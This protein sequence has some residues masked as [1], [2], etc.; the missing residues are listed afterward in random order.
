MTNNQEHIKRL[1]TKLDRL[2]ATQNAFL[3]EISDLRKDIRLLE[4]MDNQVVEET[5][6][7]ATP[8]VEE[9]QTVDTVFEEAPIAE[10]AQPVNIPLFEE[11]EVVEEPQA[12]TTPI[13]ETPK[14]DTPTIEQAQA[15]ASKPRPSPTLFN[16]ESNLEK[17]I[18][19]NLTNK[20]GIIITILGVAIG[21]KYTID[22]DLISPLT[23]IILGYLVGLGLLGFGLKLK[24]KYT[25]YSSVLVSGAM[26]IMY[27]ITFAAFSFFGLIPQWL[28]FAL[29]VIL[30]VFTVVA[31]VSY[32]RQIIALI[33]LVGAYAVPFLLSTEPGSMTTLFAYMA[34]INA[35]ILAV[36]VFRYWKPVYYAAF[37]LTWLMY[38][39]WY[40]MSYQKATDLG[41]ALTFLTVFFAIFYATFLAYK[42][43]KNEKFRIDDIML[44]LGNSFIFFGLG[45]TMLNGH[46]TGQK[47]LGLF[48]LFNAIIHFGVSVMIYRKQLADKNLFYIVSGLVLIFITITIPIQLDGNWVTLLWAGEAALLFWIGRTKNE[49]VYEILSYPL[50]VLALLSL[51]QDWEM[52]Y[53]RYYYHDSL[54]FIPIFNIRFLSSALFIAAFSFIVYIN[55]DK[56]YSPTFN[57]EID[58]KKVIQY[59]LGAILVSV[60]YLA[61]RLEISD[62]FNQLL[63]VTHKDASGQYPIPNR[64][65]LSLKNIW[66]AIY[67][68]VFLTILS[69][70]NIKFWKNKA[71]GQFN[72]GLNAIIGVLLLAI[73]LFALSQLRNGYLNPS[74]HYQAGISAILVRYIFLAVFA[75]FMYAFHQLV[76]QGWIEDLYPKFEILLHVCIIWIL[77]S[78]LIHW[79][80]MAHSTQPYKLGLSILWGVYSLLAIALGIWK[81][82]KYLRV[83]AIV[84]FGLTLLKLFVYDIAHLNTI[85]KT[86]V[87]V[88]LGVLLLIISFLYNKYSGELASGELDSRE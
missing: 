40:T 49:S 71:F 82:K 31:A 8:I 50:M 41:T 58:F 45:Y 30:T 78:E 51:V 88:S 25:N 21:A 57:T 32:D 55:S 65:I 48:T 35:G 3:R 62:Y 73:G 29:M 69:F 77:S 44:L 14:V 18:G 1:E 60:I 61:F 10:D 79:M 22:H 11:V 54:S 34:I 72:I 83:A 46:E 86:I 47:Y 59:T 15:P 87:F 42:L 7:V 23:R 52:L 37:A 6:A 20:I 5:Q 75:A 66:L 13:V 63:A 12:I 74:E 19:E 33:G 2:L 64:N 81:K 76:R 16:K 70:L 85:S 4:S 24:E 56:K 36:A 17:F 38:A 26:A 80:D 28:A 27:F 39:G 67:T 9:V 68:F 84:L 53:P 43:L